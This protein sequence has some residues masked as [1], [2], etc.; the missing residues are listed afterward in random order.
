VCVVGVGVGGVGGWVGGC[1]DS[2]EREGLNARR[3]LEEL[4]GVFSW[5]LEHRKDHC[6]ASR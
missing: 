1:C 4:C 2:R 6:V 3:V 5:P